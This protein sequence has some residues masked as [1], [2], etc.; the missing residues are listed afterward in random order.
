MNSFSQEV[1]S[2]NLV[3]RQGIKYEVNSQTP[4]TGSYV[5]Y[6]ENGQ[7]KSKTTFKDGKQDGL[8]ESYHENGQLESKVNYKDGKQEG[9]F[10][11]YFEDGQLLYKNCYKNGEKTDMSYCKK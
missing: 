2:K 10:E 5:S 1:P 4:F 11:F 6:H 3:E 7:L 8:E 9:I